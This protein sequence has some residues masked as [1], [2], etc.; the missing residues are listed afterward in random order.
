MSKRMKEVLDLLKANEERGK[1]L[2]PLA[3]TAD[4]ADIEAREKELNEITEDRRK[5]LEEK[6]KLEAE[7]RAAAVINVN[8]SAG[9]EIKPAEVKRGEE[10]MNEIRNSKEYIAAFA[11]AIR[12][13]DDKFEEC[14]A[15]LTENVASGTVPVPDIVYDIVK[16]AWE[17]EGI[18]RRVRKLY[19]KGN[20]KV[21]FEISATG[22]VSHTEGGDAVTEESLV[23]GTVEIVPTSIKKWI[24]VSDEVV[25]IGLGDGEEFL[26]YIYDELTYRI[27]KKAVDDLLALIVAA[28]TAA[29]TG[30]VGLPV[31]TAASVSVGDVAQ[32]IALL[33]DQ[34][35]DPI[36]VMNKATWGE[37]KKAQY[38]NKFSVD[39]FE[40][41]DVE[42]NNSLDSF[43]AATT[44]DCYAI[45][46]DF[47]EGAL[48]NFPN[49]EDITIKID[50]KTDMAKDLV[51]ILG[52]QYVGLGIVG[53]NAFV[54][55]I[56]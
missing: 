15:L 30:A 52:R 23:L 47:G 50:D 41:L 27:A 43:T 56:K 6:E 42:F 35:S 1:A 7:E 33:S 28:S 22:A 19:V 38:D 32:A 5:L 17:R 46:G 31:Y 29:T 45:V 24:S 13:Q 20:I 44:G 12:N 8:P 51:R 39:P 54:R 40:G 25:D 2:T 4:Q 36:V 37:Y 10:I 21:G 9:I 48:A 16:N 53:P 3:E 18:M 55:I 11:R 49:G 34:A 14:R 26:R